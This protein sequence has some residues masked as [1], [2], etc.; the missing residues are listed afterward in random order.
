MRSPLDMLTPGQIARSGRFVALATAL[1]LGFGYVTDTLTPTMAGVGSFLLA[2]ALLLAAPRQRATELLG[3][4]TVWQCFAEFLSTMQS[5]QFAMWRLAVSIA[6][7]GCVMAVIRVQHIRDLTR[8]SPD[9]RLADLDRRTV[10]G[11]GVLPRTDA[12]LAELRHEEAA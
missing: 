1:S 5:G 8:Q 11:I 12:Q 2:N 4:V 3:A 10:G 6:T 7:L 9:I